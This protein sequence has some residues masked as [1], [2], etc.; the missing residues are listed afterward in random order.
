M[1]LQLDQ[2]TVLGFLYI[3]LRM[4]GFF[5]IFP[6]FSRPYCPVHVSVF[7][8]ILCALLL[9]PG[10]EIEAV[11]AGDSVTDMRVLLAG[12]REITIGV[13]IGFSA[14][15]LLLMGQT[16]GQFLDFQMGFF[17]ASEI[18]PVMGTRIPLMG[19]YLYLFSVVLFLSFNGHHYLLRALEESL[20]VAPPGSQLSI[21]GIPA[22][23][24]FMSWMFRCALQISLPVMAALMLTSVALGILARAMPQ[25]NLFVLGIPLRIILG[26]TMLLAMTAIYATFYRNASIDHIGDIVR[27]IRMW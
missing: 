20:T 22:L 15:L 13:M 26:L 8:A 9:T 23:L 3:F 10:T 17:T 27:M 6:L 7:L 24:G 5:F 4:S 18:D 25:L 19:N 11:T 16:A 2:T 14:L 21:A 1:A 12:V